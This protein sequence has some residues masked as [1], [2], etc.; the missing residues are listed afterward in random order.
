MKVKDKLAYLSPSSLSRWEEDPGDWYRQYILKERMPPTPAMLAGRDWD[1]VWKNALSG[2]SS[3]PDT[4]YQGVLEYWRKWSVLPAAVVKWTGVTVQDNPE[5]RLLGGVP[6][7]GKYDLLARDADGSVVVVD[8]KLSGF[9]AKKRPY[10]KDGYVYRSSGK[11]SDVPGTGLGG[12]D[13]QLETYG[14]LEG[15]VWLMVDLMLCCDGVAVESVLYKRRMV[16]D[17]SGLIERYT[18]LW[19]WELPVDPAYGRVM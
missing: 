15:A 12:F 19:E 10:P 18:R 16:S 1:L 17:L 4:R 7:V 11:V 9:M 5:P 2:D 8:A 14:A 13:L 3:A 6:V